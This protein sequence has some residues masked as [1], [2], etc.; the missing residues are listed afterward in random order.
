MVRNWRRVVVRIHTWLRVYDLKK[1]WLLL[2]S[3]SRLVTGSVH[4]D[5]VLIN[6]VCSTQSPT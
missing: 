5:I 6:S 3:R 4:G 1:N 2:P